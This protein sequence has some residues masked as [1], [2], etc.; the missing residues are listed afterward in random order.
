MLIVLR[1]SVKESTQTGALLG[2]MGI[3][4]HTI[5]LFIKSEEHLAHYVYIID[6]RTIK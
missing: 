5:S 6:K 4:Y 1:K 2:G 3:N